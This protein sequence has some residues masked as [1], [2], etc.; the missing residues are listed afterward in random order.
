MLRTVFATAL[1]VSAFGLS[2]CMG[3]GGAVVS[4]AAGSA[5]TGAITS[6]SNQ[7]RFQRQSCDELEREIQGAQRAMIN[8]LT[9]PST[10]AYINDARSVATQKGCAFVA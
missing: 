8:P 3:S 7:A 6:G 9:I 4:A 5:A 10:Q 1:I 2:G